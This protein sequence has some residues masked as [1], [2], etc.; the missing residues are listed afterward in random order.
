MVDGIMI[1]LLV[2]LIVLPAASVE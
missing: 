1:L 2:A